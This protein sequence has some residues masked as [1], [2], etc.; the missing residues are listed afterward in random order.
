[1]FMVFDAD[2]AYCNRKEQHRD[3]H[4]KDNRSLLLF[5]GG[6]A[7]DLFPADTAWGVTY[8]MWRDDLASCVDAELEAAI[9]AD[10][11]ADV[12]NKAQAHC[13]NPAQA[14]K[15][16]M[17]VGAK[18]AFAHEAGASSPTLERLC[19]QLVAF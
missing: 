7:E 14:Q 3:F 19:D 15:Y 18:L 8:A 10:Q 4:K 1:M 9:G 16:T 11:F 13:G 6:N 5:L 12:K 2:S 17:L